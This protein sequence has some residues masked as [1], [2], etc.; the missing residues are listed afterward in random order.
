MSLKLLTDDAPLDPDDELLVAYVDGELDHES[1]TQLEDRLLDDESLRR[2]LQ[3]L[4]Q[5]WDYLDDFPA[6]TPCEKLVESTL[7]LVVS[8][9]VKPTPDQSAPR[10]IVRRFR[11]P[12]ITAGLCVLGV[13]GAAATIYGIRTL[14]Y[15]S[16]LADLAV[17]ENMDA[18]LA[19]RDLQLMRDLA[20]NESWSNMVTAMKDIGDLST[21]EPI[22]SN[23]DLSEREDVIETLTLVQRSQLDSNWKRFTRLEGHDQQQIRETAER[24]QAAAN[25]DVLLQTM[26]IYSVWR[27]TL[28][29]DLRDK[30]ES[31]DLDLRREAIKQ[32]IDQTQLAMSKRSS[33]NL[34]DDT[35]E[36][37]AFALHQILKQRLKNDDPGVTR[38]VSRLKQLVDS[39]RAEM[40]AIGAMV[41]GD[42]GRPDGRGGRFGF[43]RGPGGPNGPGDRGSSGNAPNDRPAPLTLEELSMIEIILS[44]ADRDVLDS[45]AGDPRNPIMEGV[46]LRYW[47]EETVRR[48]AW[49]RNE[50]ETTLVDRYQQLDSRERELIDLLPAKQAIDRLTPSYRRGP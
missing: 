35:I 1:R 42:S 32:A 25:P 15:Q 30:I 45:I 5:G 3:S 18:Y 33:L 10:A 12:L 38:F 4:Q 14:H 50:N 43:G 24:V 11:W 34:S 37:I 48:K 19:G 47:A 36:R 29:S 49:T 41:F 23:V 21:P 22:V 9:I 7:E 26:Q 17:A 27:E 40:M 8:D 2:R 28:A 31:D 13:L 44:D 39:D 6:L 20:L 16:E 46:T